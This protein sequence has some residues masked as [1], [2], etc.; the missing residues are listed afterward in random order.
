MKPQISDV[1]AR[2]SAGNGEAF[3]RVKNAF[4]RQRRGADSSKSCRCCA[5]MAARGTFARVGRR[6]RA[7]ISRCCSGRVRTVALETR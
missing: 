5:R 1:E 2:C 4:A 3:C 7:G 6:R